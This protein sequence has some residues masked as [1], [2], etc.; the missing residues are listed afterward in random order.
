MRVM[1]CITDHAC[2]LVHKTCIFART[3]SDCFLEVRFEDVEGAVLRWLDASLPTLFSLGFGVLCDGE[4]FL[5]T[6]TAIAF[7]AACGRARGVRGLSPGG[8]KDGEAAEEFH[9]FSKV[10]EGR[11][12]TLKS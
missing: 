3:C 5:Q 8:T 6:R 2:Q 4:V 12:D 1:R 7:V 9:A 10:V 11:K